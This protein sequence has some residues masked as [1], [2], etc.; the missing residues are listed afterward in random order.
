[1]DRVLI[2]HDPSSEHW[3]NT[4]FT[5]ARDIA[6]PADAT[7]YV[8]HLFSDEE[9][10][11]VQEEM[12][13][14]SGFGG[15]TPDDLAERVEEI[16]SE[17]ELFDRQ[18]IDYELRGVSGGEPVT[19]ILQKIEEL[20]IDLILVSG[21]HRSPTGKAVFG[22]LAQQVLLQAQVPVVYIRQD[23]DNTE[24]GGKLS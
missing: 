11:E 22:D 14:D 16:Q 19:Q 15:P 18:G 1:M 13:L 5:T 23:L 6:E 24:S 10:D 7:V 9:Y 4:L 8:L 20:E 12:K 17:I 2:A 21:E 3:N